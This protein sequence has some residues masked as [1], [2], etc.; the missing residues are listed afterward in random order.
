MMPAGACTNTAVRG[1]AWPDQLPLLLC[2]A[3]GCVEW[4]AD[5]AECRPRANTTHLTVQHHGLRGARQHAR[6]GALQDPARPAEGRAR[7]GRTQDSHRRT[8]ALRRNMIHLVRRMQ[9][10]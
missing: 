3:V 9:G 7:Q 8:Q 10:G 6:L 5:S 1:L 2:Q 4:P